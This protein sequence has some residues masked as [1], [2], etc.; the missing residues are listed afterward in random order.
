MHESH[1]KK[2]EEEKTISMM[3][4]V[5]TILALFISLQAYHLAWTR[6]ICP[7]VFYFFFIFINTSSAIPLLCS[8]FLLCLMKWNILRDHVDEID[9]VVAENS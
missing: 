8:L 5:M 7:L 6:Y 2:K 3:S 4:I 9:Q 1:L